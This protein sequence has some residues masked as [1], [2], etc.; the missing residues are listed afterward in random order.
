MLQN[1]A[2]TVM[3]HITSWRDMAFEDLQSRKPDSFVSILSILSDRFR[4]WSS[5][6]I[7]QTMGWQPL[8]CSYLIGSTA[9]KFFPHFQSVT[10]SLPT[11]GYQF[12]YMYWWQQ[13]CTIKKSSQDV[14]RKNYEPRKKFVNSAE[15]KTQDG[16]NVYWTQSRWAT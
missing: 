7:Y 5:L 6:M 12:Y 3:F 8:G 13:H 10:S 1:V 11:P 2:W 15:N 14:S 16:K 4:D 9:L